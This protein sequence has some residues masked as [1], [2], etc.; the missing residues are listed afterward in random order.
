MKV[1]L[2]F[3]VVLLICTVVHNVH[4]LPAK[5]RV[6]SAREVKAAHLGYLLGQKSEQKRSKVGLSSGYDL[7]NQPYSTTDSKV[8]EF[9]N[10]FMNLAGGK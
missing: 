3:L 10:E 6:L 9:L 5:S 2:P 1:I 7:M 8:D 4:S